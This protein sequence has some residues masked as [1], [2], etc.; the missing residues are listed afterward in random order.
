M[1]LKHAIKAKDSSAIMDD[2]AAGNAL[3]FQEVAHGAVDGL[4]L[5]IRGCQWNIDKGN[6][7]ITSE[8]SMDVM[9]FIQYE[10]WLSQLYSGYEHLWQC[11]MWS[12]Y[13]LKE[14]NCEQKHYAIKQPFT[15]FEMSF[16]SSAR[17]KEKLSGH[18]I[19]V[20]RNPA[21]LTMCSQD[22]FVMVKRVNKKR[23]AYVMNIKNA[24]EKLTTFNALWKIN[25]ADLQAHFPEEWFSKDYGKGYCINEVLEVY[26]CLMLMANALKDKFPNNDSAFN[27]NKL[28]EFCPRVQISSLHNALSKAT[29]IEG[30]KVSKILR[31]LIATSSQTSD[32]WCEPLLE[33]SNKEYAV[34]VSSLSAPSVTRLA[35]Y[36][37]NKFDIEIKDKGYTYENTVITLINEKLKSND[38]INDYDEGINK[39]VKLDVGEEEFDLLAR[40]DDLI[41][42]GESKSIVTTDSEISKYRTSEILQ[43]AGEQVTRK[44]CFFKKNI[45]GIFSKLGWD[46]DETKKYKVAQCIINSGQIFVGH[47]FNGIPVVDEKIL[48]AYFESPCL[49]LLSIP[50]KQ[51]GHK[52]IALQRLYTDLQELKDSLPVYLEHPPQLNHA[53]EDFEY[54]EI[55]LP[56][57]CKNSFK[58]SKV[59]LIQRTI[60]HLEMME[61]DQHFSIEK[62][63]DY[64]EEVAGITVTI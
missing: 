17:R 15:D 52:D 37:F 24:D 4:Q 34:M 44:T 23:I 25:I 61:R 46:F 16:L 33:L 10:S 60:N 30:S 27:V 8:N 11:I 22:S 64:K 29:S 13:E 26:R 32:L 41:I 7:I 39:R 38:F 51:G 50:N 19:L 40:I 21:I 2:N 18:K 5:A 31:C 9:D 3:S 48:T 54:N 57:I 55:K 47:K 1:Q 56:C 49:R 59:R 14:V 43:H 63:D 62:S 12:N 58:I 28:L 20:A 6:K 42:I 53:K 45:K 36:W 35:E